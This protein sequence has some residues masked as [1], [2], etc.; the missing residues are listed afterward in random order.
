MG[1]PASGVV[2]LGL[3]ALYF[4]SRVPLVRANLEVLRP[5]GSAQNWRQA[6]LGT[7]GLLYIVFLGLVALGFARP[8][9]LAAVIPGTLSAL[10]PVPGLSPK[11]LRLREALHFA[12]VVL[13]GAVCYCLGGFNS[14]H[15]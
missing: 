7:Q 4:V 10:A 15:F 12:W 5:G 13:C 2:L 3:T 6:I 1:P 8:W 11:G 9:T 14:L